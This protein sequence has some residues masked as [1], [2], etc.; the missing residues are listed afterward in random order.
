MNYA[1]INYIERK[2]FYMYDKPE[3]EERTKSRLVQISEMGMIVIGTAQFGIEGIMSGL[4]IEKIWS[5]SDRE[6]NDYIEWVSKLSVIMI[7]L[8]QEPGPGC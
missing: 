7:K 3:I 5:Y 6:W 8:K 1:M 4:Y 2:D